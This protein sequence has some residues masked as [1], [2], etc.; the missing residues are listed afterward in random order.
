MIGIRVDGNQQIASGHV[1]RCIAIAKSLIAR[2]QKCIFILADD[3]PLELIEKNNLAAVVL[4][5]QWNYL[6]REV[7][8][9]TCIIKE[10]RIEKLLIDS[11]FVSNN[12]LGKLKQQT[13]IIYI[14]DLEAK[15]YDVDM[16]INYS[17]YCNKK[18]YKQKYKGKN[19][20]FLLGTQ[21]APLRPEFLLTRAKLNTKVNDILITSGGSDT[22]NVIVRCLNEILNDE[23]LKKCHLHVVVGKFYKDINQLVALQCGNSNITIYRNISNMAEV[24]NKSDIA[25][26]AG[27][28]TLL[29]LCCCQLVAVSFAVADNQLN[30][31]NTYAKKGII[32]TVGDIR[33]NEDEAIKQLIDKV[34]GL[35]QNYEKRRKIREKMKD[36]T[37]GNGSERIAEAII[38]L[39]KMKEK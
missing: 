14:D 22:Y 38:Q 39:E 18:L 3:A 35:S 30:G 13:R 11:Y 4:N 17:I 10:Y 37:E 29:E 36:V 24:M 28:T 31:V 16:V 20:K 7:E 8:K 1:M 27:G 25:I 5:S 26:S 9:L 15:A 12:Y 2:N 21:Y 32:D 34:K 23:E 19:I 6:E 33:G